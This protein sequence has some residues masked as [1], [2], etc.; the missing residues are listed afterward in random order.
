VTP[1]SSTVAPGGELVIFRVSAQ[2]EVT[3]QRSNEAK[4][5]ERRRGM[6]GIRGYLAEY[7]RYVYKWGDSYREEGWAIR[8]RAS[9]SNQRRRGW[10]GADILG[11]MDRTGRAGRGG[12]E[13]LC[14]IR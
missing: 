12:T 10:G 11:R 14:L 13:S 7:T 3:Q 9:V 6:R 1:S 4:I 8:L 5:K 2:E